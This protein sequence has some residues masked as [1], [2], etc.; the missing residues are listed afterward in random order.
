LLL[1]EYLGAESEPHAGLNGSRL[2]GN[3]AHRHL[4]EL[5]VDGSDLTRAASQLATL[6]AKHRQFLFNGSEPVRIV[7]EAGSMPRAIVV[8]PESVRVLA[9]EICTPVRITK[10]RKTI[11]ITLSIEIANLYLRGLEGQWNLRIFNGI[12]TA[13]I[14]SDDGSIRNASCYDEPSGLWCHGIPTVDVP[15]RPTKEQAATALRHV[16]HFFRTFAFADSSTIADKALGVDVINLDAAIGLDESCFLVGLM[17]AVCRASLTLAPGVLANAPAYSGAGTGKGLVVKAMCIVASGA[18]PSAFTAGHDAEELDK[19]ITAGLIEARPA[20]FLDNYNSKDL[21]SDILAS[22]L[23][24]NPCQVRPMGQTKMVTLHTRTQITMTGNDVRIA[25][26]L[27][28]RLILINFDAKMEDPELR[29]FKPG[30]LDTVHS[31]RAALLSY[32]L[33]IWR[34]G[35]QNT[36]RLKRGKPLGSYEKWAEWCRDPLITLG[37]RDPVERLAAI[38]AA[39]PKRKRIQTVFETWWTAHADQLLPAKDLAQSVIQIIDEKSGF[40][41]GEFRYSRQAVTG[42]LESHTN[43]RVGGYVLIR[44][45]IGPESKPLNHYKVVPT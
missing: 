44:V 15:E 31:E 24:E 18:V 26:D 37:V 9:H 10:A 28:R 23:T 35:R 42:W 20:L 36:E 32:A 11:R 12:T 25:E 21:Q 41:D 17:T 22:A 5:V 33:T 29:N 13:P 34:W 4:P 8:T 43:T 19:R 40:R 45:P 39:D 3:G 14:L 27:A 1:D 2:N 6:I 30:F 16:R 38:K 7:N